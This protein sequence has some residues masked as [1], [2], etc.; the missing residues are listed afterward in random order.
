M[1]NQT[2]IR[3]S[4]AMRGQQLKINVRVVKD[5]RFRLGFWVMCLGGKIMRLSV[6]ANKE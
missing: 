6:K 1:I 3:A 4:D 5:W 2:A